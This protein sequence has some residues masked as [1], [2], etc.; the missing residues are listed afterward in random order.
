MRSDAVFYP[1]GTSTIETFTKN[2]EPLSALRGHV[3]V[4]IRDGRGAEIA[5][6]QEF[7]CPTRCATADFTCPIPRSGTDTFFQHFSPT[8]PGDAQRLEIL[9][10]DN[11]TPK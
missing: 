2:T 9:H 11:R 10:A 5:R 7:V 1:D 4:L 6:S 3:V 8:I